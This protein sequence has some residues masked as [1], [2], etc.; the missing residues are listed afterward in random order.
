MIPLGAQGI[1]HLATRLMTET[2]AKAPDAY[3]A[4]DLGLTA[5]LIGMVAQDYERAAEV[6][7]L[8]REEIR[9]L[10]AAARPHLAGEALRARIDGV[11]TAA[12]ASLRISDLTTLADRA[13]GVLIETH[14]AV[15]DAQA[16]GEAWAGPVGDEIWRFLERHVARHA[17]DIAL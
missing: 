16:A 15:E 5:A 3:M 14:A 9:P 2:A 7:T 11:L 12:P 1:A 17:Y 8:D 6:L 4:A 10:L 13:M